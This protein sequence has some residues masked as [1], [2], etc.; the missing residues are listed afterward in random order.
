MNFIFGRIHS[1]KGRALLE[2]GDYEEAQ[3]YL[4]KAMALYEHPFPTTRYQNMIYGEG[5]WE[6]EGKGEKIPGNGGYLLH[7]TFDILCSFSQVGIKN[8]FFYI[9]SNS[10]AIKLS[11]EKAKQ[12]LALECFPN[13]LVGNVTGIKGTFLDQV[14]E[15]LTFLF[16]YFMVCYYALHKPSNKRVIYYN[17]HVT[18]V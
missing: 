16:K 5:E 15:T 14:S 6:G 10:I 7:L 9:F 11:I 18:T 3:K 8:L 1:L 12:K 2:F 17:G 4:Y 13:I